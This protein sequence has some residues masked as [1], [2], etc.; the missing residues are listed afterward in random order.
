MIPVYIHV[1]KPKEKEKR[2]N[3]TGKCYQYDS[4][5]SWIEYKQTI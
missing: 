3:A 5:S 4:F 1:D 2:T